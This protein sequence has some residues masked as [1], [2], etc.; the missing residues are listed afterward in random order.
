M[1]ESRRQRLVRRALNELT[2]RTWARVRTAGAIAPGTKAAERF[3]SFGEGSIIV[4]P[5]SAI[6][7][8]AH[9]HLGE[10]TLVNGWATLAAGY[11]ADQPD[12]PR[13]ALVIG[14]RC[15]IGMRSS[16]VAHESIEIG[17]DVWFGPEVFVTDSNHGYDDPDL[18]VGVQLGTH[19][20]VSIGSGT[21]IGH[22]AIILPGA[23]IGRNAVVAAGSVVR[24]TVP[25]HA[26][27][28]GVPAKPLRL[29]GTDAPGGAD[30]PAIA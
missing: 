19:Q 20:P 6:Y 3:G 1:A 28:G 9:I 4:F 12:V 27:V 26:V 30:R 8:E 29:V 11:D 2:L 25:D 14:D 7:G 16:I 13:R 15:L 5:A 10:K 22:G 23:C 21:W 24:G 17:D 18:P